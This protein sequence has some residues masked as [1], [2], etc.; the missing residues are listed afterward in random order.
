MKAKIKISKDNIISKIDDRLYSSFVEHMGRA[1]YTG[2]YE[3]GHPSADEKGF[4]QD[5]VKYIEPLK[6]AHIRYPGGNFLSGYN[7][8]DGI[9]DKSKRPV[10]RDLAWFA[11]EPNQVGLNEF[12]DWCRGVGSEPMLAVN[13]GTGSPAE[14]AAM[15]EY[16]NVESG[17]QLS[18]L[19]RSHGWEKPHNVKLW[20][21]GNE[22]DGPWQICGKTAYEYARVAHETAKMMKWMDPT[23]ELVA[24]GSSNRQMATFGEWERTVLDHCWDDV[25]YLSLHSYYKDLDDDAM[26]FL[27]CGKQMDGFI[28]EVAAIC[29]EIK[30]KKHSDKN[31]YLSFD[32]WNVWYHYEKNGKE[33]A[34]WTF[35]RAIDEEEYN[36]LDALA[37][38]SLITTLINNSDVVKISCLAQLINVLAPIMTVPGG[39][40]WVQSTY[41]PYLHA[42]TWGRGTALAPEVDCPTYDCKAAGDVPYLSTAA[43]L[44][45]CG[46][47]VT[48]FI[49]N[50]NLEEDV[51][52]SLEGLGGKMVGWTAMEGH[53]LY[54]IN[55]PEQAPIGDM[56]KPVCAL[57]SIVLSK[58]SWNVIRIEL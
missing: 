54:Q 35:P 8:R 6:L 32:E 55:T 5:I 40:A 34:K 18:D 10:R 19:R 41:W 25:E 11:I 47:Y 27:S 12:V 50:N 9:G 52:L 48:V 22:M 15:L 4:R 7:W 20:C 33:P 58:A 42:C 24:C 53:D 36:F 26:S 56:E 46:K 23:V 51:Q 21:L 2:I 30:E 16:C 14:A 37:V 45:P 3:P 39:G 1:V 31:V 44:S 57:D 28:K 13:L 49:T 43:V 29:Q 17:T 38:G